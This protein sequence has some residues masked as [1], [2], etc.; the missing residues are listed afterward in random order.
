MIKLIILYGIILIVS[1]IFTHFVRKNFD[2]IQSLVKK[3][4]KEATHYGRSIVTGLVAG[5]IVIAL[6][7]ILTHSIN[8][9]PNLDLSSLSNFVASLIGIILFAFFIAS[10]LLLI[11]SYLLRGGLD[12][13]TGKK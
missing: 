6:D 13:T 1:L 3:N 10:L 4:Q 7:K 11:V 5:T 2:K 8:N 12:A 9:K